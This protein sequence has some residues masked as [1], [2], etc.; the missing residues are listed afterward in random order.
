MTLKMDVTLSLKCLLIFNGLH[1]VI[2]QKKEIFGTADMRA[3]NSTTEIILI[4]LVKKNSMA[5]VRKRTIPNERPPLVSE[6]SANYLRI[7]G[8]TW[9]A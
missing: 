3:S 4:E 6:I 9:S 1:G 2:S 5:S 7:E 8:A